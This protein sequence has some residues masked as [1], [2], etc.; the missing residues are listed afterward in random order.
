MKILSVACYVPGSCQ[1]DV[2]S[3]FEEVVQKR[4]KKRKKK[5]IDS[6]VDLLQQPGDEYRVCLIG[7]VLRLD[8]L[9]LLRVSYKVSSKVYTS[10]QVLRIVL[11]MRKT[12]LR[13]LYG[14]LWSL[15]A[16]WILEFG[17][18]MLFWAVLKILNG[19]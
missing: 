2:Q 6:K 18:L 19:F 10:F 3:Q 17:I 1:A 4:D 9:G 14:H 12:I 16:P 13:C 5:D 7:N 15:P 8:G 11:R